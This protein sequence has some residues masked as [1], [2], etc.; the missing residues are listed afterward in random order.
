LKVSN[1]QYAETG[2]ALGEKATESKMDKAS[3]GGYCHT[4]GQ[5]AVCQSRKQNKLLKEISAAKANW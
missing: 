1:S 4:L 3:R 2:K 5:K